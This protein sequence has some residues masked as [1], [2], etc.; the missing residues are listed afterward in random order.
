MATLK[1]TVI[2]DT[3]FLRLPAGTA[4]QRP[5]SP[6]NGMMRYNENTYP[7]YYNGTHWINLSTGV[8][9]PHFHTKDVVMNIDVSSWNGSS[10]TLSDIYNDISVGSLGSF[11]ATLYGTVVN[12]TGVWG[13]APYFE[14][15]QITNY[16]SFNTNCF[17]SL[18]NK[19]IYTYK[20]P[21][22]IFGC[23]GKQSL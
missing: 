5:V 16:L 12:Q 22:S 23:G 20:H 11:N 7:E 2:D 4:E 19:T 18:T 1:N 6:S 15:N 8:P 17:K 9:G 13:N 14:P 10:T 3:G 21:N